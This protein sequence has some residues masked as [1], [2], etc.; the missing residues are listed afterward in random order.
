MELVLAGAYVYEKGDA[1]A[2]YYSLK[3]PVYTEQD[4]PRDFLVYPTLLTAMYPYIGADKLRTSFPDKA[5][6]PKGLYSKDRAYEVRVKQYL[7][8]AVRNSAI[9]FLRNKL[10]G[11]WETFFKSRP[12]DTN[13]GIYTFD[14]AQLTRISSEF[15]EVVPVE[16][17]ED[18]ALK[19]FN[20]PLCI[21]SYVSLEDP[22]VYEL[23]AVY[24][25]K[26]H[27]LKYRLVSPWTLRLAAFN[28]MRSKKVAGQLSI[29]QNG[30]KAARNLHTPTRPGK[31]F[32]T[33]FPEA[34]DKEVE[35]FVDMF[36]DTFP[37]RN[38]TVHSGE[39]P[40]N[41]SH[42]YVHEISETEN[43]R[44]SFMR[45][46]LA[47]SCMQSRFD[48]MKKHPAYVY[49]S[50]DF[51]AFWTTDEAGRI[52]SR[53]VAHKASKTYAPIY[54]CTE[55]SIDLLKDH[56]ESLGYKD[57]EDTGAWE[58]A[59]VLAI[60][61]HGEWLCPYIDFGLGVI[62]HGSEGR[63][64]LGECDDLPTCGYMGLGGHCLYCDHCGDRTHEEDSLYA[65]DVGTIC[66]YC[67]NS[68]YFTC[69]R[70]HNIY[71]NE[72]AVEVYTGRYRSYICHR[73]YADDVATYCDDICELVENE[74][75]VFLSDDT[76]VCEWGDAY[77]VSD[78]TGEAHPISDAESYLGG[79]AT[80]EELEDEDYV[81]NETEGSW[82]LPSEEEKEAA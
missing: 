13:Y 79:R 30:D 11:G 25:A 75:V 67:Y 27:G 16:S 32:K 14:E 58:G 81:Y 46:S 28:P 17:F 57:G 43:I 54:G 82:E 47:N 77:F 69:E 73:D 18:G 23:L 53:S 29:Y 44:T 19:D 31:A 78:L 70:S 36:K 74:A 4:V 52:G 66:E 2:T 38:F 33:M 48:G 3:E 20:I 45:K 40:E 64:V 80:A 6:V 51:V 65:E 63:L 24:F 26:H 68:H 72:Y 37:V 35:A 62:D 1:D 10:T 59:E 22:A 12:I 8:S 56:M 39:E 41:F 50:G 71:H 15:F 9:N 42:M 60:P 7:E 34:T 76:A 61:Y 55:A 5:D 21:K 49:G